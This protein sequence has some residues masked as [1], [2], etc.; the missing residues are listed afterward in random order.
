LKKI[1][2]EQDVECRSSSESGDL[3][4]EDSEKLSSKRKSPMSN[5]SSDDVVTSDKNNSK[6]LRADLQ[7]TMKSQHKK[8]NKETKFVLGKTVNEIFLRHPHLN[9]TSSDPTNKIVNTNS[10]SFLNENVDE[11]DFNENNTN[12][13]SIYAKY[14]NLF[15]YEA[16]Q[17]DRQWL[18]ENHIIK[19]KNFKCYLLL[20]DEIEQLFLNT[21]NQESANDEIS[22]E[23]ISQQLKTFTLPESILFKINKSYLF[24]KSI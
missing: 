11:V 13:K 19:R 10:N 21:N 8:L 24:K 22:F 5:Q 2:G 9:Q 3:A 4:D 12:Y 6:K 18:N 14:P 15:R 7:S 20:F 16:D 17:S 23:L 1:N